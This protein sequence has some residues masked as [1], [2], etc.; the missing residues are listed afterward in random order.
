[1][2]NVVNHR[3]T[4]TFESNSQLQ[5]VAEAQHVVVN[6]RKTRTFES[7]SQQV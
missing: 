1:M 4:R 2:K 5:P 7:N 6:H 3:K